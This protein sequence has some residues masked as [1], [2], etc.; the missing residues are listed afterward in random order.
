MDSI[1]DTAALELAAG[2]LGKSFSGLSAPIQAALGDLGKCIDRFSGHWDSSNLANS[3][4]FYLCRIGAVLRFVDG[5]PTSQIQPY[6]DELNK[7]RVSAN[8][9]LVE[10]DNQFYLS[11]H[12]AA[13]ATAQSIYGNA[14]KASDPTKWLEMECGDDVCFDAGDFYSGMEE[15]K[16]AFKILPS[17]SQLVVE[18]RREVIAYE[19]NEIEGEKTNKKSGAGRP[20]YAEPEDAKT[21]RQIIDAA[22]QHTGK[23]RIKDACLGAFALSEANR[24]DVPDLVTKGLKKLF[25]QAETIGERIKKAA[26]SPID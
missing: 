15:I 8:S 18:L 17:F 14:A 9:P 24:F 3:F 20:R 12:E 21:C 4:A 2:K 22:R 23:R 7:L 5:S 10:F 26:K 6:I 25:E 19:A 16:E 1:N 11:F 13:L